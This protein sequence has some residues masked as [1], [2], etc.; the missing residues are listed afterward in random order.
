[1]EVGKN[2]KNLNEA[3]LKIC[4]IA[5]A[6]LKK[7]KL[8]LMD[9]DA[10]NI[11]ELD[12]TFYVS[13]IFAVLKDSGIFAISKNYRLLHNYSRIYIMK[14]GEIIEKG[15]PLELVNDKQSYLYEILIKDDIRT[16]RTMENKIEKNREIFLKFLD[17]NLFK[18]KQEQNQ[19][20][21]EEE[22]DNKKSSLNQTNKNSNFQTETLISQPEPTTKRISLKTKK[23]ENA[24]DS[25][26]V[27]NPA[28][29][30]VS[31]RAQD[32]RLKICKSTTMNTDQ[33]ETKHRITKSFS[34]EER[35]YLKVSSHTDLNDDN[36]IDKFV[37]ISPPILFRRAQI[38][39]SSS[40]IN[41]PEL[42]NSSH[43]KSD[44]LSKIDR[45]N[46]E[47]FVEG[48]SRFDLE[49]SMQIDNAKDIEYHHQ[50][51]DDVLRA[52]DEGDREQEQD[53]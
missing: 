8:I 50:L 13:Q 10:L 34:K 29:Y 1:M 6:F 4:Q 21:N 40:R 41:L 30:K 51:A 16:V 9:E 15:N 17:E 23:T 19:L 44:S 38:S 14:E 2:G 37:A 45:T 3:L 11:P 39:R 26:K 22:I 42:D 27:L 25:I 12:S 28:M 35:Y 48:A 53:H 32:S 20:S 24:N 31:D 49:N 47:F 46:G 18:I 43:Q 36:R 7:S 52:M 33:I 5:K